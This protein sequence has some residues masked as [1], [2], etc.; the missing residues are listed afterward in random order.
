MT[1][2]V[3]ASWG[4]DYR[5]LKNADLDALES[6]F[7]TQK[8]AFDTSWTFPFL[9]TSYTNMC[10]DH[11]D[12]PAV[13]G[14]TNRWSVSLRIRQTKKSMAV[15]SGTPVFPTINGGVRT[16]FS[17]TR[18]PAYRTSR[19]DMESGL[20][21]GYF[22]RDTALNSYVVNYPV[23]TWTEAGTI[24]NFYIAMG[25]P[26]KTFTF[27]DPDTGEVLANCRFGMD[28]ITLTYT[29]PNVINVSN[30]SIVQFFA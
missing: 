23:V 15:P 11:D 9:G 17:W 27:T 7:H 28:S 10:F 13:E 12:F 6:F 19:N 24:L 8:G 22:H 25:G 16:Q 29:G 1:A 26:W 5:K 20:R 14:T 3:L 18:S 21:Y 4:L 30:V 2:P